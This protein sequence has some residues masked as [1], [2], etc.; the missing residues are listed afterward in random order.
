MVKFNVQFAESQSA[1]KVDFGS[2]YVLPLNESDIPMYDGEY[3]V[4]PSTKGDK[5]L[6]TAQKVMKA[7]LVVIKVPYAEVSNT[8]GGKTATIGDEL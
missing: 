7:D 4:I 5:T 1:F 8:A 6:N 2:T 3:S